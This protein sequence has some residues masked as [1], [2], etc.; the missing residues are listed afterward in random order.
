MTGGQCEEEHGIEGTQWRKVA[1]PGILTSH[2]LQAKPPEGWWLW[3][4]KSARLSEISHR[5]DE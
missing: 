2:K 5:S 4:K 1:R 3:E